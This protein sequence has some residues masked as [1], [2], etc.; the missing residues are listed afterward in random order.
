M[1]KIIFCISFFASTT[2]LAKEMICFP[3]T[4]IGES[5]HN[6]E[7]LYERSDTLN[8]EQLSKIDFDSLTIIGTSGVPSKMQ[9]LSNNVYVSSGKTFTFFYLTNTEKTIVQETT[10]NANNIYTKVLFCK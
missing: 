2:I 7:K 5:K 3:K 1:K 6:N 10:I 8:A 4:E 9:K